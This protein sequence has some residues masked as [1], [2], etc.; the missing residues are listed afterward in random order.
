[1]MTMTVTMTMTMKGEGTRRAAMEGRVKVN[2]SGSAVLPL[3]FVQ[4][5]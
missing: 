1:M 5:Y 3:P 4:M 2:R